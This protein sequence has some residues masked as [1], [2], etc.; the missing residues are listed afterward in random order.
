MAVVVVT[1]KDLHQHGCMPVNPSIDS[2]IHLL[3]IKSKYSML[4]VVWFCALE[5]VKKVSLVIGLWVLRLVCS[6]RPARSDNV[7]LLI[8]MCETMCASTLMTLRVCVRIKG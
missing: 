3:T 8:E 6:A 2:F 4:I 1:E 7:D 5:C